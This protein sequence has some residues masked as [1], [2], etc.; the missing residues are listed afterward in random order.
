MWFSD[1]GGVTYEVSDSQLK[2]MD[3]SVLVELSDGSVMAN[4]RNNH[5]HNCSCRAV[6]VSRDGGATFQ[7]IT[8]DAALISP[9][10]NE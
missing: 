2:F 6:S 1:D 7:N 5:L 10:S 8:Y 9:V 4:M 3:E